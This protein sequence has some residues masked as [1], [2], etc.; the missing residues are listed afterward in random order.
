MADPN[1]QLH[2]I[3]PGKTI[4]GDWF[5][6]PLPLN[7]KVGTNS[8]IDSSAVFKQFFSKKAVGLVIGD[9]VTIRGASLATEED[10]LIEI[11]DYSFISN[12]SIACTSKITIGKYVFI[13]GGVNIVDSDFHPL[14][15]AARK[16]DTIALSPA[17]NKKNRPP[18][19]TKPVF[20]EDD[21]W[22][23]FNATILKG[24]R[25]GKGSIIQPG[26]V[27]NKDIPAGKLVEG[28]P[29]RIIKDV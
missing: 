17:G 5:G 21:V 24:V 14:E 8:Q 27:V 3:Q 6:K 1:Q 12:A 19:D 26:T 20:I 13:A 10:A 11:G 23:G 16:A 18:F 29:A 28:N 7:I 25:I 9:H 22:I 2:E 4:P 15:P